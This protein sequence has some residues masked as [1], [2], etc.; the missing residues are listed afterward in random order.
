MAHDLKLS[1]IEFLPNIEINEGT[2]ALVPPI[3]IV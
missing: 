2:S 1:I 3:P